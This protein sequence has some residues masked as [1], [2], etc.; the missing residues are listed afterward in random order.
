MESIE[1]DVSFRQAKSQ[2]YAGVIGLLHE[3]LDEGGSTFFLDIDKLR[4]KR[5]EVLISKI[6][7]RRVEEIQ[8][9]VV[10]QKKGSVHLEPLWLTVYGFEVLKN[11][12]MPVKKT[13]VERFERVERALLEQGLAFKTKRFKKKRL[14]KQYSVAMSRELKQYILSLASSKKLR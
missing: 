12:K 5:R 6:E 14:S 10:P 2:L 8:N 3:Q 7:E 1:S 11:L 4:K 9:T 13:T